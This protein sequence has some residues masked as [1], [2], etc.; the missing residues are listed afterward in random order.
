MIDMTKIHLDLGDRG[1]D[2]TV[3]RGLLT[4]ADE[5][6]AL[7][8]KALIVTDSGVPEEYAKTIAKRAK[9]AKIVTV[10]EGEG[11]KSPETFAML[12]R[13]M[14]DELSEF[15]DRLKVVGTYSAT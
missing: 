12:C 6:F 9:N 14:L 5:F 8:R 3:G 4:R 15:C 11:S 1:Y 10:P 2:I 7:E 13:E